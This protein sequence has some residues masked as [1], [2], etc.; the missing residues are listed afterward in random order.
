MASPIL[1]WL[2]YCI[3]T[4]LKSINISSSNSL[5]SCFIEEDVCLE[6]ESFPNDL[7]CWL[8]VVSGELSISSFLLL[9]S[10]LILSSLFSSFSGDFFSNFEWLD[11]LT[12]RI[13]R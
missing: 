4:L 2:K 7:N 5:S 10:I 3:P 12:L 6:F 9:I 1:P 13:S 8:F 11:Y